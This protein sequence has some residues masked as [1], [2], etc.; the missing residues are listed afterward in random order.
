VEAAWSLKAPKRWRFPGADVSAK[1]VQ[2]EDPITIAAGSPDIPVRNDATAA[3]P[4][5]VSVVVKGRTMRLTAPLP[6]TPG[7]YE[8]RMN[9]RDRRFGNSFVNTGDVAVFISGE[10]RATL[11]LNVREQGVEAGS[12]IKVSVNAANTGTETWAGEWTL[13]AGAGEMTVERGTR[14][15]AQWVR[16]GDDGRPADDTV[17][18]PK[19]IV[20]G[21][22]PLEPGEMHT[23]RAAL[24]TPGTVGRWA[25]VVDVVDD[26]DGSYAALG[27]KP[28]VAQFDVVA[29][30]A[31]GPVE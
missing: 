2:A 3:A 10:R 27:S 31:R 28:A 5:R 9:V 23:V 24:L 16:L 21:D 12:P 8:L 1:F 22:V 17:G 25:L 18:A 13:N 19:P 4:R 15:V 11:R 26:V 29:A 14:L 7:A 6:T 30:R 20:L